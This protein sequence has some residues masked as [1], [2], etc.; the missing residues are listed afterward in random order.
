VFSCKTERVR[1]L[2][3]L[4]A[5]GVA[6]AVPT[7]ALAKGKVFFEDTVPAGRSSAVTITVHRTASFRVLLRVPTE[8]R[9]RLFLLGK[10]APRGG[11]LIDT[12]SYACEGAA[13]SFYCRGSYERAA[14]RPVHVAH[15]LV[16]SAGGARRADRALVARG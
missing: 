8:G 2:A 11:P 13:G 3:V 4:A 12:K 15:R 7:V 10:T 5:L 9:A 16:R 14:Q 1:T 6:L